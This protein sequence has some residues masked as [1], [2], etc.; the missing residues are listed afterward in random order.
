MFALIGLFGVRNVGSPLI[1]L[2]IIIHLH[3]VLFSFSKFL[4]Q[5][6]HNMVSYL[7][8]Y[9]ILFEE[10]IFPSFQRFHPNVEMSQ[11]MFERLKPFCHLCMKEINTCCYIY[12]SQMEEMH[13]LV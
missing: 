8:M 1:C 4:G 6:M 9:L 5:R 3:L 10:F 7:E 12:H 13:H 2:T 11:Q